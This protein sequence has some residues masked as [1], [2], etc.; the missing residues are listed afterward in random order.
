MILGACH[1]RRVLAA[2]GHSPQ[3]WTIL[4]HCCWS[5]APDLSQGPPD[6]EDPWDPA[7]GLSWSQ[8][9]ACYGRAL[10]Q[11]ARNVPAL[12]SLARIYEIRR[13]NQ[14]HAAV[15]ASVR[16]ITNQGPARAVRPLS[17]L[18]S[19]LEATGAEIPWNETEWRA[20]ALLNLGAPTQRAGSTS[21]LRTLR[22]PLFN[23]AGSPTHTLWRSLSRTRSVPIV[24]PWPRIDPLARA[25]SDCVLRCFTRAT[26]PKHLRHPVAP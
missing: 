21:E 8:A 16:S 9:A 11:S 10:E 15:A 20:L 24:N 2:G 18:I 19:A 22:L 17:E 23:I 25:G 1:A 4:G 14:A 26:L 3:A 13:M 7:T 12:L 5:L 6:L